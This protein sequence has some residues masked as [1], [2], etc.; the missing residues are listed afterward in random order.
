M[1]SRRISLSVFIRACVI[2]VCLAFCPGLSGSASPPRPESVKVKDTVVILRHQEEGSAGGSARTA[3]VHFPVVSGLT[4]AAVMVKV[5]KAVSLQTVLGQSVEQFQ[6]DF[7]RR[8]TLESIEFQ[9]NHNRN[10]IL[11]L[12]FTHCGTVAHL[13]CYNRYVTVDLKTGDPIKA[14]T[15][16]VNPTGLAMLIDGALQAEI[17]QT[18]EDARRDDNAESYVRDILENELDSSDPTRRH[19]Y[20]ATSLNE[21][22][23]EE[24]GVTFVYHYY[25]SAPGRYFEPSGQFFFD[26][27]TLKPY[28]TPGGPFARFAR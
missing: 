25:F 12:T 4:N 6:E 1:K 23:V 20:E 27:K 11:C 10:S 8:P 24:K 9:V 28:I 19:A 3:E 22:F 17:R 16:F 15:A 18:L 2:S 26:W 7:Q 13:L 5:Q 21:F 14:E